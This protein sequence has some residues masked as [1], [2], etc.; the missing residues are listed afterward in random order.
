MGD[1]I[2]VVVIDESGSKFRERCLNSV[3]RQTHTATETIVV[4]S[5]GCRPVMEACR[6]ARGEYLFFCSVTSI[7]QDNTLEELY[8]AAS[9][10]DG[11]LLVCADLYTRDGGEDYRRYDGDTALYGK[12]FRR[13]R[14]AEISL[15]AE[16]SDLLWRYELLSRYLAGAVR[17]VCAAQAIVY[18]TSPQGLEVEELCR[19]HI[20]QRFYDNL[21]AENPDIRKIAR[22]DLKEPETEQQDKCIRYSCGFYEDREGRNGYLLVRKEYPVPPVIHEVQQ[23]VVYVPA[24]P[25][26][27]NGAL[28]SEYMIR[29]FGQGSMGLRTI[30]KSMAA[31]LKYKLRAGVHHE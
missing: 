20:L 9:E 15:M 19:N 17:M 28:L 3:K 8:R 25:E 16:E 4:S 2:S 14:L 21:T 7:I 10:S 29:K 5:A 13:D 11:S 31:W 30:V 1:L 22:Y 12:L 27:W 18:E 24:D 6:T 26:G 23:E